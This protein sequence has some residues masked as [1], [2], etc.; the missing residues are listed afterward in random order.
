MLREEWMREVE[1][2]WVEIAQSFF[3]MDLLVSCVARSKYGNRLITS[4]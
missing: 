4:S 2:I 3:P 1:A